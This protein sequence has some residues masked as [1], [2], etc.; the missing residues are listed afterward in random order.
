MALA[1]GAIAGGMLHKLAQDHSPAILCAMAFL[2]FCYA[3]LV[4][5]GRTEDPP[6]DEWI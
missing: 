2:L 6:A 4:E 3:A 5:K 1:L